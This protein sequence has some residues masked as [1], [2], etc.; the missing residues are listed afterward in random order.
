MKIINRHP[1]FV[2]MV[3]IFGIAMSSICVR[4]ST[5]PS[6]VTAAWRLLW[7]V[8]LLTPV[9]FGNRRIRKELLSL[10]RKTVIHSCISGICLAAH[11][12]LWFES[13]QHTSVA[14]STTI[15]CTE[16]I[17]VA[18]G[19]WLFQKG[20]L[21][22]RAVMAIGITLA[23]SIT[24]AL[25]DFLKGGNHL[26]G[27]LLALLAAI[28]EAGYTLIGKKVRKTVSTTCYTYVVYSAC[29]VTL[30]VTCFAQGQNIAVYGDSPIIAGLLLAVFST[31]LGHSLFSWCL[32]FFSPSFVSS[33]KLCEPVVAAIIAIFAF[34]EIPG[35]LL[36]V[37]GVLILGGVF[38][39]SQIEK[40]E[41][42]CAISER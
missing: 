22:V 26:L 19:Y 14:A 3:G 1:L 38:Y 8:A 29:A 12:A 41:D 25:T 13:L 9:M 37:G 27:D 21:S 34:S 23:G 4:Y 5:A 11:L 7:A 30:L 40:K 24:I 18:F 17:W 6:A 28:V 31:I 35:P 15:V 36:I 2:L 20:K 33:A 42:D 10:D 32:K 39:Y 16:V